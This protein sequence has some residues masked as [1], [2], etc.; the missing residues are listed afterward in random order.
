MLCGRRTVRQRHCNR[1][2]NAPGDYLYCCRAIPIA[3][4]RDINA[5]YSYSGFTETKEVWHEPRRG[6]SDPTFIPFSFSFL[7]RICKH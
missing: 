2:G 4:S 1:E 6:Y 3:W 5:A 7:S